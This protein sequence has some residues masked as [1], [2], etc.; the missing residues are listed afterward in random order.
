MADQTTPE[1]V[2]A[3]QNNVSEA[4]IVK[5]SHLHADAVHVVIEEDD[6]GSFY[7]ATRSLGVESDTVRDGDK[8]RGYVG[9]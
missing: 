3:I 7:G 5:E 6:I 8:I 1:V 2:E 4:S 9:L